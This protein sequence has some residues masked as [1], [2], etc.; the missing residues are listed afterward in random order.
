MVQLIRPLIIDLIMESGKNAKNQLNLLD[1]FVL[2]S[3]SVLLRLLHEMFAIKDYIDPKS[4]DINEIKWKDVL[5]SQNFSP[6]I[7]KVISFMPECIP[8]DVRATLFQ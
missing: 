8:F 4:W 6:E 1:D 7:K 2:Y 3:S 5:Q